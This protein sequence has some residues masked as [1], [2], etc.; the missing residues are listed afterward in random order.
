MVVALAG[1][2]IDAPGAENKRF[3]PEN[4][5]VVQ[6]KIHEF[7]INK[8]ASVLVCAAA[9]GS[10]ILALEAAGDLLL[11]R[12]IVLPYDKETFKKSSVIDRPGDWGERYDR[13]IGKVESLGDLVEFA[14]DK[15]K[16]ETYFATNID[17]LDQAARIADEMKGEDVAALVV[18]NGESRGK[19]DVTGH[20]REEAKKRGAQVSEIITL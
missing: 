2:R 19:S 11:R 8:S 1:R 9:C 12:R 20:F 3:P 4:A 15:D 17:I 6:Q 10:D 14:H 7:L 13:I 18:W 5:A 16:E